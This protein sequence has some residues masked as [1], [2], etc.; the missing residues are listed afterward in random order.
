M[1]RMLAAMVLTV[2]ALPAMAQGTPAS[3]PPPPTSPSAP[4]VVGSQAEPIVQCM[5]ANIPPS[6][7]VRE[8]ELAARDRAGGER[9]LRGRLYITNE[10]A[11]FRAMLKIGSPP[12][13]AGAAYLVREGQ[14]SDEI[15]VFVPALNKVRR[16]TGGNM[17]GPLWGTDLSYSDLKQVQNAFGDSTAKLEGRGEL[18]KQ[19]VHVM[20]FAPLPG[21]GSR[22]ALIRAWVDPKTCIALKSEFMEGNSVRKRLT[23]QPKDLKQTGSHWY[24][25]E[26]LVAD[27]KEGTQTR[28]KVT[29]V[30]AAKDIADRYF[31]PGAFHFGH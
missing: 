24:L 31:S 28:L 1:I 7:Q 11:R 9:I 29:G 15:Y 14:S 5:R 3:T 27:L 17:D 25:S 13:L 20:T 6:V 16:V 8:V 23:G 10:N 26:I 4:S 30:D 22:Y 2:L 12:D 18:D 19:P 21:Q